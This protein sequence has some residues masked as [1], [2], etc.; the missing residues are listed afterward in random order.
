M[1]GEC[2]ILFN[3]NGSYKVIDND[4]GKESCQEKMD[5]LEPYVKNDINN[6]INK[7]IGLLKASEFFDSFK[8]EY[9][10]S[11]DLAIV[12]FM[13]NNE[14]FELFEYC[15][16]SQKEISKKNYYKEKFITYSGPDRD[17]VDKVRNAHLKM[18]DSIKKNDKGFGY[19]NCRVSSL[20]LPV[21][22]FAKGL[23]YGIYGYA[24]DH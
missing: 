4:T 17:L 15:V 20:C 13:H 24:I 12:H 6:S 23:V 10:R 9:D 2:T 18:I 1:V 21:D 8:L 22:V 19:Y 11:S 14:E 3:I 7:S 5:L 16:G